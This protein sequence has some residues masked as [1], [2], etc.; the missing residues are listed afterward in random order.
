[1][2]R[3]AGLQAATQTAVAL[4]GLVAVAIVVTITGPDLVHIYNSTV[5]GCAS[6]GDC[7]AA[8]AAL[9][10]HDNALRSSLGY[11]VA[12][13][14]GI[15]GIFCGAPLVARE[16]E[17][18]TYRLAWTQSVTRGRWIAVKLAVLGLV[19]IAL[20]GLLSLIVTV[21]AGPLDRAGMDRWGTFGQRDI[22]PLAYAAFAFALGVTAG[23]LI[24]RTIPAMAA[25]LV[26][27]VAARLA[28]A[29]WVRPNLLTPVHTTT[30][31][32]SETSLGFGPGPTG[33][34]FVANP[35]S[36]PNTWVTASTIVDNTGRAATPQAL[37]QFIQ[38]FCPQIAAPTSPGPG[39]P[40]RAPVSAGGQD[41]FQACIA[42]LSANYHVVVTAQPLSRYWPLQWAET[43]IFLGAAV[44]LAATSYWWTRKR[45]T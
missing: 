19:A 2:I 21:W 8:T 18:G 33:T 44:A 17:T 9:L 34:T 12:A 40:Q 13:V 5:A 10:N 24:R 25:T 31:L 28:I 22:V 20:A 36:I 3:F 39:S 42:H 41:A 35:P 7:G 32:S 11:L 45:L 4:L 29:H 14:P 43:G 23:V 37:H 6:H 16:L 1:M 26:G 15:I 38:R 30:A 27:F